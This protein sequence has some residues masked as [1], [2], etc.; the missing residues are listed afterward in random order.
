MATTTTETLERVVRAYSVRDRLTAVQRQH[1]E[2]WLA[3]AT[4]EV[5]SRVA[6]AITAGV[7]A[8]DRARDEELA[9]LRAEVERLR[10]EQ[11]REEDATQEALAEPPEEGRRRLGWLGR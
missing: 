1:L 10:A 6:P 9:R 11:A 3:R 8:W 4:I 5:P 7:L 2:A